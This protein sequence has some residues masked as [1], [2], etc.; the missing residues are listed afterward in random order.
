[1]IQFHPF[2]HNLNE[3]NMLFTAPSKTLYERKRLSFWISIARW[4]SIPNLNDRTHAIKHN[5]TVELA[6]T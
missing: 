2:V 6:G 5:Q 4:Q 3:N 1:M